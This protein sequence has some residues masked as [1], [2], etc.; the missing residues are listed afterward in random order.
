[1]DWARSLTLPVLVL[2]L[3]GVAYVARQVRS[4][5]LEQINA[6][7]MRTA[8]AK[9]LSPTAAIRRHALRPTMITV[10]TLLATVGPFII[11]GSVI[12]ESL[13]GIDGMGRFVYLAVVNRDYDVVQSFTLLAALTNMFGIALADAACVLIDPR[14]G[15]RSSAVSL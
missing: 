10:A 4:A 7:Y 6:Q 15:A 13:F 11:G 9:G 3:A 5:V 8:R 2:T 12:V 14:T 1:V